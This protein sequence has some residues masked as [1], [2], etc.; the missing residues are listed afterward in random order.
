LVDNC[1]PP[2]QFFLYEDAWLTNGEKR[3]YNERDCKERCRRDNT[4]FAII[5]NKNICWL[6]CKRKGDVRKEEY[7]VKKDHKLIIFFHELK[8][9]GYSFNLTN[10][11][12]K[13][14]LSRFNSSE[15]NED[16]CKEQCKKID[17]CSIFSFKAY[18]SETESNCFLYSLAKV[19]CKKEKCH[20]LEYDEKFFTQFN[21]L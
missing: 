17:V 15:K 18:E 7:S 2:E 1:I 10:T 6:Y 19:K 12:V 4:C 3:Y 16:K 14:E 5:N 21:V 8:L 13:Q 20:I 9:L 11:K